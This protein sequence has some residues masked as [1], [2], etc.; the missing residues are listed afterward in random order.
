MALTGTKSLAERRSES[1]AVDM[2]SVDVQ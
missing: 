2:N 1:L